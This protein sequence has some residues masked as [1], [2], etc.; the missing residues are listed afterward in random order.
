MII[1][2][3]RISFATTI[4]WNDTKCSDAV[5]ALI[6]LGV[7]EG[8]PDGTYALEK[9]VT[10]AQLAKMLVVC[11]GL[12]NTLDNFKGFS[13]FNDVDSTHWALDYINAAVQSKVIIGYPDGTFKPEKTVSYIEAITMV[14]RALGYSNVVDREGIWP[15]AYMLKAVELELLDDM[16]SMKSNDVVLRGNAAILLWNM[17]RTPMWRIESESET[18]GMNLKA[19][20]I[21]LNIKFPNFKYLKDAYLA[22]ISINDG[23]VTAKVSDIDNDFIISAKLKDF[24]LTHI[25]EGMRISTLIKDYKDSE[26]ATFL[27]LTPRYSIIDG[28]VTKVTSTKIEID[29]VEYKMENSN[30]KVSDYVVVE[31]N[32]KN[33]TTYNSKAVI[34]IIPTEAIEVKRI[35]TME[36]YIEEEALVIIEGKWTTREEIQIGDMYTILNEFGEN[37]YMIARKRVKGVFE[38]LTIEKESNKESV[39]YLELDGKKFSNLVSD[40][41]AYEGKE[42]DEEIKKEDLLLAKNDNKYLDNHVELVYNYLDQI[43]KMNFGE[44]S[45]FEKMNHFYVITSN[46]TWYT[47]SSSGKRYHVALANV[48]GKVETYD[49]INGA[50]ANKIGEDWIYDAGKPVFVWAEFN[51]E[52]KIKNISILKSGEKY[53]NYQLEG[54]S[55]EISN[56]NYLS[57]GSKVTSSTIVMIVSPIEEENE[58]VIGFYVEVSQGLDAM[59]YIKEGLVA[60]DTTTTNQKAKYVFVAED[61]KSQDL[62]FGF[63]KK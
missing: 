57:N 38:S 30:L 43:V 21:M 36:N 50:V 39:V 24:D 29:N 56:D 34:K 46:G 12:G 59:K 44:I 26:N 1:S 19:G 10:R 7:M 49:F 51:Q 16:D 23:E 22:N 6:A 62:K 48:N 14:I 41:K 28:R 3:F 18:N 45:E 61:T 58:N 47:S 42:N 20:D 13:M 2:L 15:T 37:Y 27:I 53:G 9:E 40:F 55:G 60:Y 32:G 8:F 17:L 52:N 31:V 33:V 4:K 11:L 63:I 5:E 25:L 35:K 54:F